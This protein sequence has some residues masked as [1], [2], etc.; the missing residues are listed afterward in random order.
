M[1]ACQIFL[2]APTAMP[3]LSFV[4]RPAAI[5]SSISLWFSDGVP[6][7]SVF[8]RPHQFPLP[9]PGIGRPFHL[10][11]TAQRLGRRWP[12][13]NNGGGGQQASISSCRNPWFSWT[14]NNIAAIVDVPVTHLHGPQS[15]SLCGIRLD[16]EISQPVE[17][18]PWQTCR[19]PPSFW[20][21]EAEIR[22]PAASCV[23][24]YSAAKRRVRQPRQRHCR[25]GECCTDF[26]V[27]HP[28]QLARTRSFPNRDVVGWWPISPSAMSGV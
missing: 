11:M 17:T 18:S 27:R 8:R 26:I 23:D 5:A 28:R 10:R 9:R 6:A 25:L 3:G 21:A 14:L 4:N 12:G 16:G 7:G 19:R 1:S 24:R 20:L 13:K 22:S 2:V 15:H